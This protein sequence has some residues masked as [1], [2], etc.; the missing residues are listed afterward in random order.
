MATRGMRINWDVTSHYRMGD[1]EMAELNGG[2][3]CNQ[4][5]GGGRSKSDVCKTAR[6][7]H[8]YTIPRKVARVLSYGVEVHLGGT[9]GRF[10]KGGPPE[11]WRG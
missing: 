7:S 8:K 1:E 3:L 10:I 11:F 9:K 6:L 2:K 4:N 5:L